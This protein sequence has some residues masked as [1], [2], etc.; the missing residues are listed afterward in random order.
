MVVFAGLLLCIATRGSWLR[1][2]G[3]LSTPLGLALV[4]ICAPL[5][6]VDAVAMI[7]RTFVEDEMLRKQFPGEWDRWA[8]KVPYRL[9]PGVL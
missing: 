2:S 3:L 4:G 9:I 7:R 8:Q 6:A 5:I 1:E